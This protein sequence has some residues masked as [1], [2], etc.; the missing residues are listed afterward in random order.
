MYTRYDGAHGP[1]NFSSQYLHFPLG[2]WAIQHLNHHSRFTLMKETNNTF[3]YVS[4]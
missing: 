4:D 2:Q 3:L 1:T